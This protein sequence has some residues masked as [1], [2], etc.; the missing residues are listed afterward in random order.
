LSSLVRVDISGLSHPGK[1]RPHN[2][3]HFLIARFG[4]YLETV[5][6]NVPS[7]QVPVRAEEVGYAMVVADGMGGH[8]AGEIASRTAISGLVGL[9]LARPDWILQ[10]GGAQ[11]AEVQRRAK[12]R[13]QDVHAELI[14]RARANPLLS[15]MGT[16][17]TIAL[18]LG[19][20]LQIVHVGDSRA[21]L[22]RGGVLHRLTRDHTYVQQL[23]ESGHMSTDEA[24]THRMRHILT[25]VVGGGDGEVEIDADL[26]QLDDG[27]CLLLCSDG[28]TDLV[29]DVE[30]ARLMT[31][32]T[33][34]DEAC[35]R[36]VDLALERGGADNITV[37]VARYAIPQ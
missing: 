20:D 12:E 28:L 21:Y 5:A 7:A 19:D 9:A 8:A 26:R 35:H 36:L 6:T 14:A 34:S 31:E 22:L 1:V 24:A 25:S 17:V 16:T 27:D 23:V 29:K 33:T 18:S 37:V 30:I 2:E 15:G 32:A 4:R 10:L 13:V 3:D 11:S